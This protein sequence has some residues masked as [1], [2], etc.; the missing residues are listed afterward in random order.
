MSFGFVSVVPKYL[1]FATFSN[2]S[3][4]V[5]IFWLCPEFVEFIGP[6]RCPVLLP[7]CS[8][9]RSTSRS[10]RFVKMR[11]AHKILAGRP[12]WKSSLG[13][14]KRRW[15]LKEIWWKCVDWIHVAE[16]RARLWTL[17]KMVMNHWIPWE[18]QGICWLSERLS[19]YQEYHCSV[20]VIMRSCFMLETFFFFLALELGSSLDYPDHKCYIVFL[21]DFFSFCLVTPAFLKFL[22]RSC[23]RLLWSPDI[24]SPSKHI[25]V[26]F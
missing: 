15:H 11:S 21:S 8:A 4:D 7:S 1:N 12:E 17:V 9:W 2:Y 16:D 18:G 5:L 24:S 23:H 13:R 3:L 26:S 6:R 25:A 19:A 14:C 20:E 22:S 10:S